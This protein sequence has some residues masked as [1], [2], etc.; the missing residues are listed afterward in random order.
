MVF[1]VADT[2]AGIPADQ[3]EAVF[4]K[5]KRLK[6]GSAD[7]TGFGLGLAIAKKIVELH[8]GEIKAEAGRGGRFV[9]RLRGGG[10][11]AET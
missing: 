10:L 9:L 5:Y 1:E 4:E 3:L 11:K 7:E 6:A 8:G 2:G